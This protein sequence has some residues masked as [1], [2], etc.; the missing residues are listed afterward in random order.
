MDR[1]W[2]KCSRF[3]QLIDRH[4]DESLDMHAMR[5]DDP[6]THASDLAHDSRP[7]YDGRA[8]D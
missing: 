3:R 1:Y 5:L 7:P 2:P 4:R 8:R 6:N